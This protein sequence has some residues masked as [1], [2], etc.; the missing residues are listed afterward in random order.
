MEIQLM[1]TVSFF[2]KVLLAI[3][4]MIFFICQT[5]MWQYNARDINLYSDIQ[6][7]FYLL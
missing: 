4:R 5:L 2:K 3:Y 6:L 1:L 7:F